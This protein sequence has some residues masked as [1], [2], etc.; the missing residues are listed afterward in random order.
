MALVDQLLVLEVPRPRED[1]EDSHLLVASP[2]GLHPP[3]SQDVEVLLDHPVDH[4]ALPPHLDLED[5]VSLVDLLEDSN[6]PLDSSP[7]G[8]E[9]G[10][11]LL[12]SGDRQNSTQVERRSWCS[13]DTVFDSTQ[14]EKAHTFRNLFMFWRSGCWH[15]D[16]RA[17]NSFL[18]SRI[19]LYCSNDIKPL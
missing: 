17:S 6:H 14:R 9:E 3:D 13:S 16:W 2:E 7:L 5:Q 19:K 1:L 10:S 8:R 4:L 12:D 15:C 11:L 18:D